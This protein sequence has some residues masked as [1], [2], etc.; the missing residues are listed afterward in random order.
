LLAID[1]AANVVVIEL[2]RTHD[3]GHMEGA[4]HMK[5]LLLAVLVATVVGT[6]P[7]LAH[8][9]HQDL[10]QSLN[11]NGSGCHYDG[12]TSQ[13]IDKNGKVCQV[14]GTDQQQAKLPQAKPP[15]Q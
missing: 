9:N 2:K 11:G 8:M 4:T 12:I 13:V 3:G 10:D 15:Q 1:K 7:A 5:R 6:L 14:Q